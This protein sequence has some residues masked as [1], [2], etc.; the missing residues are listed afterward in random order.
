MTKPPMTKETV[1]KLMKEVSRLKAEKK[2]VE[3]KL[4]E[5]EERERKSTAFLVRS[6]AKNLEKSKKIKSSD[7][8]KFTKKLETLLGTQKTS[9]EMKFTLFNF[10]KNWKIEESLLEEERE[11]YLLESCLLSELAKQSMRN[12]RKVT[13]ESFSKIK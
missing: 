7:L 4:E 13:A 10:L 11:N 5:A 6:I 12:Y 3:K 8:E 1:I 2:R 9:W